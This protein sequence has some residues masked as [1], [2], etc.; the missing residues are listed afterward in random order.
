MQT[1]LITGVSDGIGHALAVQYAAGGARVL[2]V[3]R[4]AFPA[5]L[6]GSM[7]PDDYMPL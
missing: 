5:S 2:G 6:A 3:G 4:R 7:H 1:I